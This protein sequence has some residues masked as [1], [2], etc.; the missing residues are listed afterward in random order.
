MN[1][2]KRIR[3]IGREAA[4]IAHHVTV[5]VR[6]TSTW[7]EVQGMRECAHGCK[8]YVRRKGC[9]TQYALIHSEV[10]GCVLGRN[11]ETKTVPV[12]VASAGKPTVAD[13]DQLL[14]RLGSATPASGP[15]DTVSAGLLA[16]RYFAE[17]AP[18]PEF[19]DEVLNSPELQLAG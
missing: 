19:I 10:Y 2:A 12:T 1:T 15:I 9:V 7:S 3:I 18:M 4:D 17:R 13:D 6:P 8:L 11:L 14:D 5:Y 16:E